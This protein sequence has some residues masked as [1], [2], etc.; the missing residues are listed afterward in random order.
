MGVATNMDRS[1]GTALQQVDNSARVEELFSKKDSLIME[2]HKKKAH[3]TGTRLSC[4]MPSGGIVSLLVEW[5]LIHKSDLGRP[6]HNQFYNI[7]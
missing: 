1:M 6:I 5:S 4:R 7:I 3:W 2:T